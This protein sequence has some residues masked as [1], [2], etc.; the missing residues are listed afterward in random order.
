MASA[1]SDAENFVLLP[2]SRAL[3]LRASKSAPVAPDTAATL[4][5]A[6][7]KSAAVFTAA[8]PKPVTT[9]VTGRN[10][11]PTFVILSPTVFSFSPFAA[12]S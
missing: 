9:P 8:A 2:I 4:L 10:F 7:S 6:E 1:A 3:S 12:I 11:F 5:M